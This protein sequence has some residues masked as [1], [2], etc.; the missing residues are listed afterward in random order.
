MYVAGPLHSSGRMNNNLRA[1][2]DVAERLRQGGLV[3]FVPHLYAST[4]ALVHPHVGECWMEIDLS[5]LRR[6]DVLVRI[7]HFEDA[8]ERVGESAGSDREE[9]LALKL[10]IPVY[11]THP[12]RHQDPCG[13]RTLLSDYAAGKFETRR[14][15]QED[16]TLDAYQTDAARTI[17]SWYGPKEQLICGAM[18]LGGEAGEFLDEVKKILFH[19]REQDNTTLVK[20]LGDV[21]WYCALAARALGHSLS[22]VAEQNIKKLRERYPDGFRAEPGAPIAGSILRSSNYPGLYK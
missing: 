11:Y 18:G 21:M 7:T 5:W 12:D 10:G 16:Y 22:S 15:Q 20:E 14:R 1:A 6:C 13:V 9:E 17:P 19:N 4:W 8:R 2:I 3:P